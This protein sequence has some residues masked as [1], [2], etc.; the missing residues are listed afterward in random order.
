MARAIEMAYV[1][2]H[3]F[4]VCF[5]LYHSAL[6]NKA[7]RLG[8][9]AQRA[10]EEQIAAAQEMGFS[11]WEATGHLFRAG[12]LV[13]QGRWQE[14]RDEL[15]AGLPRF[16]AHGA[17]LGL[18]FYRGYLAEAYLGL[19]DMEQ[20]RA[21]LESATTAIE[22][23]GERFH[24]PEVL[25]L[26]GVLAMRTGDQAGARAHLERSITLARAQGARAWVLR[27]TMTL[28]ELLAGGEHAAQGRRRLAEV[29]SRFD[30][31]A[32]TP[33]LVS[34]AALLKTLE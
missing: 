4:S 3:P 8:N 31:G 25:R 34:A 1:L 2:D 13:E 7:C 30:E 20:A 11:F 14:A 15:V 17:G 29:Y 22:A 5:V 12:G 18:P 28:A 6:L 27:S 16:E 32:G 19:G 23:S 33:D 9:E 26:R 10:G 21:V 24:E